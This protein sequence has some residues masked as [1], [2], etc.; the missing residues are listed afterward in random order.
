[1]LKLVAP[2]QKDFYEKM[3]YPMQEFDL[4][5]LLEWSD[6]KKVPLDYEGT[7]L[8][9]SFGRLEGMFL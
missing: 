3:L 2:E 7:L 6:L 8:S 5:R 4:Q 1:M 9:L